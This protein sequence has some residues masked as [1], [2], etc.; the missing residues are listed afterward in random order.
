LGEPVRWGCLPNADEPGH[1]L[2][3]LGHGNRWYRTVL[4][5]FTRLSFLLD[6]SRFFNSSTTRV[7]PRFTFQN[8]SI[9]ETEQLLRQ[10]AGLYLALREADEKITDRAGGPNSKA[11]VLIALQAYGLDTTFDQLAGAC[12][13]SSNSVEQHISAV[14]QW[15][16][17]AF[18][19][20]L[21]RSGERVYLTDQASTLEKARKLVANIDQMEKQLET[22][23]SCAASLQQSGHQVQLP[24]KAAVFLKAHEECKQLGSGTDD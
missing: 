23:R 9:T 22:V 21:E 10:E 17:D 11:K 8:L 12:G 18:Q 1:F 19:L 24:A 14:R 6:F 15:L 3:A 2:R 5:M 13:I 20:Q 7:K 4:A 16:K